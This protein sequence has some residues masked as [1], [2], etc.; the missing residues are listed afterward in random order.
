MWSAKSQG[1]PKTLSGS[2]G[3]VGSQFA[4]RREQGQ[5]QQIGGHHHIGT[6]SMYIA[7][8]FTVVFYRSFVIRVLYNGTKVSGIDRCSLIITG[9]HFNAYRHST[10]FQYIDGLRK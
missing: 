1:N 4:G 9:H 3:C 7:D 5:G 6:G 8:E 2:Y 10:G